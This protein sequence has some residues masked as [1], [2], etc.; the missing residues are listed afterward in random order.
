[1]KDQIL[2]ASWE[3]YDQ[4]GHQTSLGRCIRAVCTQLQT[5]EHKILSLLNGQPALDYFNE[6]YDDTLE[7][8][9]SLLGDSK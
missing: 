6:H 2:A 9:L 4:L 7:E 3:L 8:Q 1:M 5:K